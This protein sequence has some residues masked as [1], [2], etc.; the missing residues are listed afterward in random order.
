MIAQQEFFEGQLAELDTHIEKVF[1]LAY[2]IMPE[3]FENIV[4]L[5]V[6]ELQRRSRASACRC[7]SDSL[8]LLPALN[9]RDEKA[10]TA[11]L[12]EEFSRRVPDWYSLL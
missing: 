8:P 6:P 2:A 5:L 11:R 10:A 7:I 9:A 4:E 3:T 12:A 1:N